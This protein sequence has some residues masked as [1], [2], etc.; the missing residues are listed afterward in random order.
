MR[1]F[2]DMSKRVQ[3]IVFGCSTLITILSYLLAY[4]KVGDVRWF[5]F[6]VASGI[7]VLKSVVD[8]MMG[9]EPTYNREN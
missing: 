6:A 5:P 8:Y 1:I 7:N 2:S 4:D 3:L 9:R